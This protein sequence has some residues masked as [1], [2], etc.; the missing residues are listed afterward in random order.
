VTLGQRQVAVARE[1]GRRGALPG[2]CSPAI[3]VRELAQHALER[4]REDVARP[5]VDLVR[6]A[7]V[8]GHALEEAKAAHVGEVHAEGRGG[9]HAGVSE[10][11][12]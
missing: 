11:L 12:R 6:R 10:D 5:E 8:G 9:Q 4:I 3:A 7:Q 2:R 1:A